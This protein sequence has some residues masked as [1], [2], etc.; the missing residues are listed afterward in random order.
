MS[1]T[2][3]LKRFRGDLWFQQQVRQRV[4]T[5]LAEQERNF[6][7]EHQSDTND[8][9]LDYLRSSAARLGHT[10][11]ASEIIGGS[12]YCR[13]FGDWNRAVQAAGLPGPAPQPAQ[14]RIY[15]EEF[16]R[17]SALFKQER[18]AKRAASRAAC[19][20]RQQQLRQER[21]EKETQDLLWGQAH[22]ADTDEQ[23]FEY[24]RQCARRLGHTP[25]RREV[26]GSGYIVQ[27]IGC[28]AL[29]LSCA[30]LPLPADMKPPKAAAIK[31]YRA[32]T[33]ARAEQINSTD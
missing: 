31:A 20:Q 25:V 9:L 30:G 12:Y 5:S 2:N 13:R 4:K 32:K 23:L 21:D 26:L 29:V 1:N 33:M 24:V 16:R 8:Q 22:A 15:Q 6:A 11:N 17:Q 14:S 7:L 28:W 18:Q 27:R 10:P 3:N 19:A